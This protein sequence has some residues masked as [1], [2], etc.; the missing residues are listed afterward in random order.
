MNEKEFVQYF[1]ELLRVYSYD[2]RDKRLLGAFKD[3]YTKGKATVTC[4]IQRGHLQFTH[5]ETREVTAPAQ[6]APAESIETSEAKPAKKTTE[7]K[8]PGIIDQNLSKPKA[9]KK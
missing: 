6:K 4:E 3:L 1:G 7:A 2:Y 5:V 8:T 9:H